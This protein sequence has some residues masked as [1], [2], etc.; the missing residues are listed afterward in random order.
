[1][2]LIKKLATYGLFYKTIFNSVFSR[3]ITGDDVDSF[4][5]P[6]R[7]DT[8]DLIF[9]NSTD[10][11]HAKIEFSN[12][13]M[14]EISYWNYNRNFNMTRR[15]YHED[16]IYY[17]TNNIIFR[18]VVNRY[19]PYFLGYL[20][21][22][23]LIKNHEPQKVYSFDEEVML[24]PNDYYILYTSDGSIYSSH[25]VTESTLNT[26]G[27]AKLIFLNKILECLLMKHDLF[28]VNA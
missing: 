21:N 26:L 12:I 15:E 27:E 14:R 17:N 18:Y 1:M 24:M 4:F 23:S 2:N 19:R 25:I 28:R 5:F 6:K 10:V 22:F 11:T 7:I 9:R 16:K 20:L 13:R 8:L 3:Y